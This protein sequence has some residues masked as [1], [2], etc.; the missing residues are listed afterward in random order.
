M[1]GIFLPTL[2]FPLLLLFLWLP[3]LFLGLTR[4]LLLPSGMGGF[5]VGIVRG[6]VT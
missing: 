1:V 2:L 6:I 5:K 4:F 3:L